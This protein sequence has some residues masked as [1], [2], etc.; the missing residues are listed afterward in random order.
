[1]ALHLK[2]K[3]RPKVV[4]ECSFEHKSYL[5]REREEKLGFWEEVRF[6]AKSVHVCARSCKKEE[7]KRLRLQVQGDLR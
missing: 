7:G 2:R 1:M 6:G 5:R 4:L 3:I